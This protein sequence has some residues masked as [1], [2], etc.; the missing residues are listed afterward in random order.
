MLKWGISALF[1]DASI[2]VEKDNDILFASSS[3]R[4]SRI[5]SDKHLCNG[6]VKEALRF[7]H[8]DKVYWYEN[9]FLKSLRIF[10]KNNKIKFYFIKRYLNEFG[11]D[12]PIEYSSHHLSHLRSSSYTSPFDINNSIGVVVDA[13]GEFDSLSMWDIKNNKFK[14]LYSQKYPLSLGLFYSSMT[15]LIGLNPLDEEYILMG[16]SAY[17]KNNDVIDKLKPLLN[18]NLSKGCRSFLDVE[19]MNKF[20]VAFATQRIFETELYNKVKFFIDKKGYSKILYSGGCALN[21]KANSLLGTLGNLWIFPNPGDSG[22]GVGAIDTSHINFKDMFLGYDCGGNRKINDIVEHLN[23]G[24]PVGVLNGKAEFGPRALGNRSIL[25]D[26]RIYK[27]RDMV[28]NIKGRELFRPFAPCVLDVFANEF[29]ELNPRL[30]YSFMQFTAKCKKP[31]SIPSVVHIDDTCRVQ[32]VTEKNKFL[33]DI[34]LK[35]YKVSGCP[36]L[37][38]TSLNVK[39]KPIVNSYNDLHE[40]KNNLTIF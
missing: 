18:K 20:D 32:V 26:P 30:D 22:S 8:P 3:E 9:T 4:F 1:H 28:N 19:K 17:G 34:L 31:K 2:V 10:L 23:K 6:L 33:Y 29:F 13:V 16:M 37:L 38:N 35:W 11:I 39:G 25:A 7:G 12:C 36:V 40:F 14:K 5:K 24:I 21:C 15:D 27:M